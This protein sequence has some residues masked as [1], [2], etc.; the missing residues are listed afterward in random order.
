[1]PEIEPQSLTDAAFSLF[2]LATELSGWT[3]ENHVNSAG[4][5]GLWAATQPWDPPD[6]KY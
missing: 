1:L 5:I 6:A 3:E 4:I 2:T